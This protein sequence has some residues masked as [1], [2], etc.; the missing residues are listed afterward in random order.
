MVES[1]KESTT[2]LVVT[3]Q[4]NAKLDIIALVT[5]DPSKTRHVKLKSQQMQHALPD[6]TA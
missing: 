6:G 2:A 3:T 4:I 5:T 1:A